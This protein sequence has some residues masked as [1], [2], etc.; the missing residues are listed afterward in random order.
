MLKLCAWTRLARPALLV[1]FLGALASP[2]WADCASPSDPLD[3]LQCASTN[4]PGLLEARAELDAMKA[5]AT[6]AGLWQNPQ[7]AGDLATGPEGR[8]KFSA[9]W[10]QALPLSGEKGLAAQEADLRVKAAELRLNASVQERVAAWVVDLVR[11]RQ[12]DEELELL[13]QQEGLGKR[14]LDRL[15]GLAYLTSEQQAAAE[16]FG[17]NQ[18]ALEI[19]RLQL[20]SEQAGL[21]Q[22][23]GTALGAAPASW[24]FLVAHREEWPAFPDLVPE[25]HA[26]LQALELDAKAWDSGVKKAS[27]SAWP[28]LALGPVLE[29]ETASEGQSYFAGG[30]IELALPLWDRKQG[31]RG[32]A[33]IQR[34]QAGRRI[35]TATRT[36]QG[37]WQ[38]LGNRYAAAVPALQR[39][40]HTVEDGLPA[41]KAINN[42]YLA[43]RLP[44]SAALEAFRQYQ[45]AVEQNHS[46][47]REA[48]ASL[49]QAYAYEGTALG[50]KP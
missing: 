28:E 27:A 24:A 22:A 15:A 39:N 29:S 35:A 4:D 10:M 43:G 38:L 17:W 19:S 11:L 18:K 25:R 46:L 32:A 42:A 45:D 40:A 48:L 33:G 12:I 41:L 8:S 3:Y 13:G 47:E 36:L 50:R 6:A 44:V 14:A 1:L 34:E 20:L 23:L 7:V 37:R 21:R 49:W 31:E 26:E 2:L 9:S 30:A 16:T 5:S